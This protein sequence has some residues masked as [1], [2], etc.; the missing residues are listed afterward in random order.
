MPFSFPCLL[1]GWDADVQPE[2]QHPSCA[3]RQ[4]PRQGW[5]SDRK[6]RPSVHDDCEAAL[7]AL[8]HFP[9]G[10]DQALAILESVSAQL[11]LSVSTAIG[12]RAPSSAG[13]DA[14]REA[15]TLCLD[16]PSVC[17]AV[18]LSSGLALDCCVYHVTA[19]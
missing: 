17:L 19:P 3:M 18:V 13:L 5:W 11:H 6:E 7:S 12:D 4:K 15:V 1:T 14:P 8:H 10:L 9:A 2:L 16:S